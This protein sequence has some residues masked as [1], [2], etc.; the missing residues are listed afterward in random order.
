GRTTSTIRLLALAVTLLLVADPFLVRS[1]G[2]QLSVAASA[3]IVVLAPKIVA[4]VPGPSFVVGPLA[5]TIAAQVGVAPL[6]LTAFGRLPVA[7][8]PANL[9]AVPAAGPVMVWGLTAGMAAGVLGG[10]AATVLQL[11]TRVLIWWLAF[12]ARWASAAPLGEMH[13]PE[14]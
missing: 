9:L 4:A 13:A 10:T 3:A 8:V 6:L 2:F 7:S 5:I 14:L 1:V 11:P 12:V